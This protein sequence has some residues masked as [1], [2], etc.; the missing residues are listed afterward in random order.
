MIGT[1]PFMVT[2]LDKKGT[3]VLEQNPNFWG[4]P[5]P[6]WTASCSRCTATPRPLLRDLKLEPLD[7]VDRPATRAGSRS[8]RTTRTSRSG[9]AVAGLHRDRLQLVPARRRRHACTG[10]GKG[11]N[12][13]VVQDQAIRQALAY[14]IDR[15]N[16][17]DTVYAG[18]A[19][20]GNGH[21]LAVLH[22]L[23]RELRRRPRGRLP[24]TT[25]TRPGRSSPTAAGRARGR[26]SARRTASRRKFE[27]MTRVDN[28]EET[29]R[30]PAHQG[31]GARGRHRHRPRAR[32]RGRDQQHDL[33]HRHQGRGHVR[34]D[35]RRVPLGL[36]RRPRRPDFNFEVLRT[37]ARRGRTRTTRTRSTTRS[38]WSR[39]TSST[40]TKRTRPDARGRED[41][42]DATCR[43]SPRA[44]PRTSTSTRTDTW[45]NY[46]PSPEGDGSPLTRTGCS[47]R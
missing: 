12:V 8:S 25:R 14:A 9:R 45:H 19:T 3:T 34:A 47:S 21:H 33:R 13:A 30:R 43:T 15:Q 26:R 37:A 1:G 27:L 40:T 10:P 2:K 42:P 36:G 11:V 4:D 32:D 31:L 16:L 20:P 23:L 6:R 28:T 17:V 18:Q 41:R 7:A 39:A 46:Q 38:R 29:E 22:P 24:A 35:L 44:R 5:K